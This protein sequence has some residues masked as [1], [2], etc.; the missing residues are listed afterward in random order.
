MKRAGTRN[1]FF[2]TWPYMDDKV[3]PL[4]NI[5]LANLEYVE[6]ELSWRAG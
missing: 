4:A 1:I 3:N 6:Q 5:M 2:F